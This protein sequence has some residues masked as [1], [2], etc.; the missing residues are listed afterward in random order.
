MLKRPEIIKMSAL[1]WTNYLTFQHT[2]LQ[3]VSARTK[4]FIAHDR[5]KRSDLIQ[6]H[7]QTKNFASTIRLTTGN[8]NKMNMLQ[9]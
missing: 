5:H 4:A 6:N 3:I 2:T 8:K 1:K 9:Q 7:N